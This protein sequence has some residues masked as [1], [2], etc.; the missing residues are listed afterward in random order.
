MRHVLCIYVCFISGSSNSPSEDGEELEYVPSTA[1]DEPASVDIDPSAE[2]TTAAPNR[3][4]TLS[5]SARRLIS[6]FSGNNAQCQ[7]TSLPQLKAA[8]SA[9]LA[10]QKRS[11]K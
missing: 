6:P 3:V 9:Q 4:V 2:T 8:R 7:L 1:A 10:K 5:R 11:V